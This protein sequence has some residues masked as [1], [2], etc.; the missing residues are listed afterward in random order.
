MALN[1]CHSL[2][3]DN[4][5]S[6]N[7]A[8]GSGRK[9]TGSGNEV[10]AVAEYRLW[11]ICPRDTYVQLKCFCKSD[12]KRFGALGRR[13]FDSFGGFLCGRCPHNQGRASSVSVLEI[14]RAWSQQNDR[15]DR[16]ANVW[17]PTA[18]GQSH[19]DPWMARMQWTA[20]PPGS[21]AVNTTTR[22]S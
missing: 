22:P 11:V 16:R 5:Q 13:D 12:S 17:S 8:L 2:S 21:G 1:F 20:F 6:W 10:V 4:I 3:L 14:A 7:G 18:V 15:P 9:L 19:N